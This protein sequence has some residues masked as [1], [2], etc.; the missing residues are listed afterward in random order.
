MKFISITLF[1][2]LM[3]VATAAAATTPDKEQQDAQ[4][5]AGV[6]KMKGK[7][8]RVADVNM[9]MAKKGGAETTM[10][11]Q[12]TTTADPCGGRRC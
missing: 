7:D 2:L 1:A 6:R 5:G 4:F 10:M 12:A 3:A 11:V 8:P 9:R